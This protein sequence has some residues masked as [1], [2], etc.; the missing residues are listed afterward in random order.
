MT[1]PPQ[2]LSDRGSSPTLSVA[3]CSFNGGRFISEQLASISRQT[4]PPKEIIVCDDGSTD[5]TIPIIEA[6]ARMS[7][8]PVRLEKH[9]VA[10][11]VAA[12]F[13][14]AIELCTGELIALADQDDIWEPQKLERIVATF[15]ADDRLGLVFTDATAIDADGK[16]LDY[17]LWDALAPP[18]SKGERRLA[19]RG[20]LFKVLL[21]HYVVTGATL[22]FRSRHRDLIL[23]IPPE[24][25]HDAWI[26]TLIAAVAPC[27]IIEEP[28]IRYRQHINQVQGEKPLSYIGQFREARR[29][30]AVRMQQTADRFQSIRDRLE[31]SQQYRFAPD[32]LN[33]LAEKVS[34]FRTRAAMISTGRFRLPIVLDELIRGRYHRYSHPWKWPLADLF[35]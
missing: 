17:R 8:C 11:G 15:A 31:S 25:L 14:R 16:L 30:G 21:R 12:N 32:I 5:D 33:G 1:T 19:K 28:L 3:V 9:A 29:T 26:A 7:P 22:A 2:S 4:L 6:F 34:H 24:A 18:F 20:R 10:F 23:P 27:Q 35:L 13:G